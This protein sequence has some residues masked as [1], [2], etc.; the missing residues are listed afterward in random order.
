MVPE[1]LDDNPTG[2]GSLRDKIAM[3]SVERREPC[4]ESAGTLCIQFVAFDASL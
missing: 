1:V 4:I 2:R 3:L